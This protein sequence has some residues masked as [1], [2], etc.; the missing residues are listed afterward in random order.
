M[1]QLKY[2]GDDRDFFKY[3]LITFILKK[4]SLSNYVFIPMLT[5]HRNDNEGQKSSA[6]KN[7]R[8]P[9]LLQFMRGCP[10]KSLRH[11]ENWISRFAGQ[12]LTVEPVDSIFF[13]DSSRMA[14]WEKFNAILPI[15][16][17]LIFIDPDTGLETGSL[18]Y[19]KRQGG[20]DKYL[21]N[22]ELSHLVDRMGNA[23]V[24]MIYQHLSRDSNY[25]DAG[26]QKKM[27]QVIKAA[28]EDVLVC[29]YRENDLSFLF[30]MKTQEQYQEVFR[31]LIGYYEK[32]TS[33]YKSIYG[34]PYV[35]GSSV[36]YIHA[37]ETGIDNEPLEKESP[38]KEN[39]DHIITAEEP[40]DE[41]LTKDVMETPETASPMGKKILKKEL[42]F[43]ELRSTMKRILYHRLKDSKS[44]NHMMMG[45]YGGVS[46]I[47]PAYLRRDRATKEAVANAFIDD[48]SENDLVDLLWNNGVIDADKTISEYHWNTEYTGRG[49][50]NDKI[51]KKVI[52][53]LKK[54]KK[55]IDW[56]L[57]ILFPL[58]CGI[59]FAILDG[60]FYWIF[61]IDINS[62]YWI[63]TM[64]VVMWGFAQSFKIA[65]SSE[66]M[67]HIIDGWEKPIFPMWDAQGGD[68]EEE[69]A[70]ME[71]LIDDMKRK[72]IEG[73]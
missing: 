68:D 11:W 3:D 2:F 52:G 18:S 69:L 51:I 49:Y 46:G 43:V 30:V 13:Q 39:M 23:S 12:Y 34:T 58:F 37:V 1:V 63:S 40:Q 27:E 4:S 54:P 41:N 20:R 5:E 17:A 65:K 35:K 60:I 26:V 33:A 48:M 21:L 67:D 56:G 64:I 57:Y 45:L 19:Q 9:E 44:V 38:E 72:K 14:Y 29:A 8:S 59:F 25:H 62:S 71:S 32:S 31:I 47:N 55:G 70:N 73:M 50:K 15:K 24:L 53:T 10:S 66:Y 16:N 42:D 22:N 28:Y 36:S 61:N 6:D 7:D